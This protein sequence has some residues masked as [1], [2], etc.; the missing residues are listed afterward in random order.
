[1][2]ATGH[3]TTAGAH[4]VTLPTIQY[5]PVLTSGTK[6]GTITINGSGK[7]LYA[8]VNTNTTYTLSKDG[9]DLKLTPSSGSVQT[10]TL[11]LATD[12]LDGLMSKE[13]KGKLDGI[14]EN[15]NDFAMAAM[16]NSGKAIATWSID[17]V[18]SGTIYEKRDI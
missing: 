1:M 13:D 15:A 4:N 11:N 8:P 10:V 14:S 9:N 2:N 17:G 6:I 7:D 18:S 12:A 5:S 3:V 16:N